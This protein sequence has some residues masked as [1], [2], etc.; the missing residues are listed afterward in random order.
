MGTLAR[1]GMVRAWDLP[2]RLFH[3][4]LVTLLISAWVSFRFAEAVGDYTLRWHRWNGYAILVLIVFRLIW[5][6]VGSSTSR[7]ASFVSWPW[8]AAGYILDMLRGRDRRYL[9]HNPLGAWMIIGLLT[10]VTVQGILGLYT[11][12]HNDITAGPLYRTVPEAVWQQLSKWHLWVFYW[13][14]LPLVGVHVTANVLYGA[15]KHEPLVAAMVTG[16]KPVSD[17]EDGTEAQIVKRPLL[18]AFAV[19]CISAGIVFGGIVLL[20]GRL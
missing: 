15:V 11:V 5:G 20:G 17:Y 1:A 6:L 2:T 7:F 3:W 13:V 10:V 4:T 12:E 18:R 9:G 19:L 16:V 8:S 14:I